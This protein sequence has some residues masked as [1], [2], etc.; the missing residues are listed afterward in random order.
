[1]ALPRPQGCKG[2]DLTFTFKFTLPESQKGY[3]AHVFDANGNAVGN[4]FTLM[5]GGT[6]SIKAGETIRVYDLK[7]ATAIA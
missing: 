7:K 5:N 1:M 3:E 6:H 2:N 4:S